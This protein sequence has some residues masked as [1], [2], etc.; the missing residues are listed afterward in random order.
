M[1]YGHGHDETYPHLQNALKRMEKRT[2]LPKVE[3]HRDWEACWRI[4]GTRSFRYGQLMVDR[5]YD[6]A[7]RWSWRIFVGPIPLGRQVR[8]TCGVDRCWNPLHLYLSA[9]PR[10]ADPAVRAAARAVTTAKARERS[11][12]DWDKVAV[13]RSGEDSLSVLADRFGVSTSTVWKI[14]KGLTWRVE[15]EAEAA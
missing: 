1:T 12:L 5:D 15:T 4:D 7:H 6:L 8:H 14:R 9:G 3:G 13:I 10:V 11:P 2:Y